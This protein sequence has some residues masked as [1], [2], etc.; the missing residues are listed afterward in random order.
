VVSAMEILGL[1]LWN[2]G[3]ITDIAEFHIAFETI[4]RILRES[5]FF[6][7][8]CSAVKPKCKHM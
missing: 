5:G 7:S 8:E 1:L 4:Y 3:N 6:L 2:A